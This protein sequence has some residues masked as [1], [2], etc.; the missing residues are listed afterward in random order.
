MKVR[1][2]TY[3]NDRAAQRLPPRPAAPI[4]AS[5]PPAAASTPTPQLSSTFTDYFRVSVGPW[6]FPCGF[7]CGLSPSC[8]RKCFEIWRASPGSSVRYERRHFLILPGWLRAMAALAGAGGPV[9]P[10]GTG[11]RPAFFVLLT[12]GNRPGHKSLTL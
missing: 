9:C 8:G 11:A 3:N 7:Q 4:P 12:A 1:G 5:A 2:S 10:T 6:R